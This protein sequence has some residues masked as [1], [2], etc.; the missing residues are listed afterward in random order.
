MAD[1]LDITISIDR[2]NKRQKNRANPL[3]NN[4]E[5]LEP[6]T[7]Y[8]ITICIPFIDSFISQLEDRFLEHRNI[9]CGELFNYK[10]K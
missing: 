4:S 5:I 6:E 3:I 2:L 1:F 10:R 8:R 7:Y 9:F